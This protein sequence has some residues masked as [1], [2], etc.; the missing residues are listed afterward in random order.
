MAG[1]TMTESYSRLLKIYCIEEYRM[2]HGLTAPE[3]IELFDRYGVMD[4]LNEPPL[5]WQCI[6]NTVLDV[7]DFIKARS[8]TKSP[9]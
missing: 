5:Q 9:A 8:R 4:F 2:K 7:E 3:T 1:G 6:E